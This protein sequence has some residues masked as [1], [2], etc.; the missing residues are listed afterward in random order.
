MWHMSMYVCALGVASV[1]AWTAHKCK[2]WLD[3]K[4]KHSTITHSSA[5]Y[6][7]YWEHD[8]GYAASGN[9]NAIV[10][11]ARWSKQQN[12]M[13]T[14]II[15]QIQ[16]HNP[17]PTAAMTYT[18]P[19]PHMEQQPPNQQLQQQLRR[20]LWTQPQLHAATNTNNESRRNNTTI[21]T[22]TTQWQCRPPQ[23]TRYQ[24]HCAMVRTTRISAAASGITTAI[25]RHC[26]TNS[27]KMS[28]A[29]KRGD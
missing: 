22:T 26:V 8:A 29:A 24:Q 3:I 20:T 4:L 28:N 15:P 19:A 21:T 6:V 18:T 13:E 2:H 9:D 5:D 16:H 1:Q 11:S 17:T 27:N 10:I 14:Q 23:P 7:G 25:A 12:N